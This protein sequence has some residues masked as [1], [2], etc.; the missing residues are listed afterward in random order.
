[1]KRY[2]HIKKFYTEETCLCLQKI[3]NKKK[4]KQR[5][6]CLSSKEMPFP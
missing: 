2:E 5:S 3:K 6:V 1:M 4:N